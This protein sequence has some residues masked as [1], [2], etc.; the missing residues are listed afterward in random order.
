LP[1]KYAGT[2][3]DASQTSGGSRKFSETCAED[4]Y[5]F[6]TRFFRQYGEFSAQKAGCSYVFSAAARPAGPVS[7]NNDKYLTEPADLN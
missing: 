1:E 6:R 7:G 3:A 4:K 2:F 5:A